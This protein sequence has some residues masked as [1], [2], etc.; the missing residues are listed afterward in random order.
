MSIDFKE[1]IIVEKAQLLYET[2][3]YE[4]ALETLLLLDSKPSQVVQA[5]YWW[6]YSTSLIQLK[7]VQEALSFIL[8]KLSEYPNSPDLHF[9]LAK[10]HLKE[11]KFKEA[12][13]CILRAIEINPRIEYYHSTA[14]TLYIIEKNIEKAEYHLSIAEV[15]DPENEQVIY[16]RAL[17]Y[18]KQ[19]NHKRA[20]QTLRRGLDIYPNST[21]LLSIF[22]LL[23]HS[24]RP[25]TSTLK[26]LSLNAL[27][28][29]PNDNNAQESLLFTLKNSNPIVQFFVANGFNRYKVEWGIREIII[30]IIFW[31][32]TLIWG[33]FGLLYL[34]I[35]WAGTAF[36]YTIIRYHSKYKYILPSNGIAI[37][38]TFLI[39]LSCSIPGIILIYQ[40]ETGGKLIFS[41]I[42]GFLFMLLTAI[43]YFKITTKS[44]RIWFFAFM[45]IS[46]F[47]LS[48]FIGNPIIFGV[49]SLLL[50]LI[51]AFLFTLN[52]T[53]K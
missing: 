50:L 53:F 38:N 49:L 11:N 46:M 4:E 15:L 10:I 12:L 25:S 27:A 52:I 2:R 5:K 39:I 8:S 7:K 14:S 19:N 30:V 47:I 31:K 33:G 17:I 41:A 9:L 34:L 45:I 18:I 20:E 37:S 24:Y 29:N 48:I 22:T 40:N 43:S 35:N 36:F 42:S 26:E 13:K 32:G 6:I 23:N 1:D 28:E 51:Y 16:L 3:R 44:G 21:H